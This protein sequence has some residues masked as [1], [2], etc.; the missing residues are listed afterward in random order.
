MTTAAPVESLRAME[1]DDPRPPSPLDI[2]LD[3]LPTPDTIKLP[4]AA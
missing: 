1:A 4:P 2:E 3:K